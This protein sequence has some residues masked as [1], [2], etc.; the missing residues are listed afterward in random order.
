VE[1]LSM[2]GELG[3]SAQHA[4]EARHVSSACPGSSARQLSMPR[5]LGTSAQ[6]A[7]EARHAS[8][9]CPRR[10]WKREDCVEL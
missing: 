10:R 3:T 1:K 7:Q 6:H 4:Q 8:S 9:A 5:K 2:P